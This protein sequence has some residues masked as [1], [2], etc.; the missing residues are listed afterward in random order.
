MHRGQMLILPA[1]V[2]LL[3]LVYG[4]FFPGE[5]QESQTRLAHANGHGTLRVGDEEFKIS[6]VIVKLLPDQKAEITLV[7]DITIFLTATWSNHAESQHEVNLE[8]AAGAS[9]GGLEGTGKAS[10]TDN[11]K[12]LKRLTLKGVSRATKRSVEANFEGK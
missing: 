9:R 10:L 4:A 1:S 11:S 7:A 8:F 12:S 3:A 2:F 6:S 5:A